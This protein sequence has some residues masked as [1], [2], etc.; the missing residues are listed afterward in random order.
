MAKMKLHFLSTGPRFPYAYYLGIVTALKVYED[1][2]LWITEKPDSEYFDSLKVEIEEIKDIPDFPALANVDDH[3]KRV[4]IFDHYIWKIV[5]EHGGAIMG[6]DS[7]T[8]KKWD[9]LLGDKEMLVPI[10]DED[11][12]EG[13]KGSYSMHGATVIKGSKIARDIYEDS[14]SAM[15][16][17]EIDGH[18]KAFKDGKIR[19]GGAGIIPYLNNI[20]K[21]LDKVAIADYGLL[22][23]YRHDGSEFYLYQNGELLNPD[24]R[25]IPMYASSQ[26]GFK[27][28]TEDYVKNGNTLLSKLINN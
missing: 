27:G 13:D 2:K 10:D 3:L 17:K 14:N 4:C 12:K 16:G 23:G 11:W 8:I 7:I 18:F 28:I 6:L 1:V 20:D 25:T 19:W 21:N 15:Y 5:A 22:G 24:A 9:D 26:K